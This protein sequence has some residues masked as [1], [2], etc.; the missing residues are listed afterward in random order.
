MLFLAQTLTPAIPQISK[1]Q[2]AIVGL[3]TD[4]HPFK[5]DK[6]QRATQT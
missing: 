6:H 3:F 1:L 4:E 2:Q 5:Q